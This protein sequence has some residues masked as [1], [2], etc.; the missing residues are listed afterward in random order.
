MKILFVGDSFSNSESDNILGYPAILAKKLNAEMTN[1]S[2]ACSSLNYMFLKLEHALQTENYD[3]VV[4]T[5]TSGIRMHHRDILIH[6][7]FPQYN[8]GTLLTGIEKEAVKLFY[9][10]LW[11]DDNTIIIEKLFQYA[12]S[13]LT[14][15]Y[16]NTKFI[17]LP[18]FNEW[19]SDIPAGNYAFIYPN[20]MLAAL[21]DKESQKKEVAGINANRLNHMTF[22]QNIKLAEQLF[23]I[24][25]NYTFNMVNR[26]YVDL[27]IL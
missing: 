6:S 20:L 1:H 27:R 3:V 12:M 2:R 10:Y 21:E 8:D 15:K 26:Y 4:A 22:D 9:E 16:P 14:L 18:C 5:V 23:S 7:G 24:I 19:V 25:N 13:T 11:D 17:F